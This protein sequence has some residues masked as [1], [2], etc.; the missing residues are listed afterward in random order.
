MSENIQDPT[1]EYQRHERKLRGSRKGKIVSGTVNVTLGLLGVLFGL[2]ALGYLLWT[3]VTDWFSYVM[4]ACLLAYCAF[5]TSSGWQR[6]QWGRRAVT[7]QEVQQAKQQHRQSLQEAAQGNLPETYSKSSRYIY[8]GCTLLFGALAAVTWY[9]YFAHYA[10][11]ALGYAI[12]HTIAMA[13][14]LLGFLAS[15]MGKAHQRES[16]AELRR[17]LQAGEFAANSGEQSQGK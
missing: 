16:A 5:M 11:D 2:A 14:A 1:G 4:M 7:Q 3:H 12:G 9:A 6:I 8:L 13:F 10:G 17:I 15:L